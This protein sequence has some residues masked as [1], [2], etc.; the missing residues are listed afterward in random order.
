MAIATVAATGS[1]QGDAAAITAGY[2]AVTGADATKGVVL[3]AAVAEA[4]CFVYNT[5]ASTL[6][7][8]PASGDDINDG[9]TDAALVVAA[10]SCVFCVAQDSTTWM[11]LT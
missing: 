7:L 2:T 10:K 3:P 11:V 1:V 6:K 5:A 9:A 4:T 8:Y